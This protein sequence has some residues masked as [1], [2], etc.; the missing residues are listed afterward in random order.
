[1]KRSSVTLR[2]R[3]APKTIAAWKAYKLRSP[4]RK[5][6]PL[7]RILGPRHGLRKAGMPEAVKSDEGPDFCSLPGYG[8]AYDEP[9]GSN[10]G[11][12]GRARSGLNLRACRRRTGR[13]EFSADKHRRDD[14]AGREPVRCI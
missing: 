8:S 6:I 14:Q 13:Q 5:P 2:S 12:A 4:M 7:C 1:M 9:I 10:D 11:N 3:Y